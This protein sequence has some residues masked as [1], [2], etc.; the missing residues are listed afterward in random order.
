ME[1]WIE[2]PNHQDR[3]EAIYW[4]QEAAE[5]Y[6]ISLLALWPESKLAW[7]QESAYCYRMAFNA[8]GRPV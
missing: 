8:M 3:T 5:A 2:L 6:R 4:Q 7:Q 1:H